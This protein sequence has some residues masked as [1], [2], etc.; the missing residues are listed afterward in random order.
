MFLCCNTLCKNS[1]F[2]YSMQKYLYQKQDFSQGNPL[3]CWRTCT[4]VLYIWWYSSFKTLTVSKKPLN[5]VGKQIMRGLPANNIGAC[6]PELWWSSWLNEL[7][8]LRQVCR[9]A[10]GTVYSSFWLAIPTFCQKFAVFMNTCHL[11]YAWCNPPISHEICTHSV[12]CWLVFRH[13]SSSAFETA[14]GSG[15]ILKSFTSL[16]RLKFV[17]YYLPL[18]VCQVVCRPFIHLQELQNPC[19]EQ[20]PGCGGSSQLVQ[21]KGDGCPG[22]VF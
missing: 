14:R 21:H 22:W 16:S 8:S 4:E 1:Q 7:T 5:N 18:M 11:S 19:V 12:V 10:R 20:R 3:K 2:W 13:S 9:W 15:Y 17:L 6:P